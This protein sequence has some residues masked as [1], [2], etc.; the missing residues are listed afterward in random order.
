MQ[1][2]ASILAT[3]YHRKSAKQARVPIVANTYSNIL[4]KEKVYSVYSIITGVVTQ[5]PNPVSE[6]PGICAGFSQPRENARRNAYLT[7]HRCFFLQQKFGLGTALLPG[8]EQ[9][10][11]A[12]TTKKF[13]PSAMELR[14]KMCVP[15]TN[16]LHKKYFVP[17]SFVHFSEIFLLSG[18][19]P[20]GRQRAEV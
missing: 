2:Y 12:N 11:S 7:F 1:L 13:P 19:S 8:P 6:N 4:L 18:N 16:I 10:F 20:R 14:K 15:Q 17:A 5:I 9:N 3:R